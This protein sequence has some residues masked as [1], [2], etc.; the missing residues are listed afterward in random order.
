MATVAL[1]TAYCI[2]MIFDSSRSLYLPPYIRAPYVDPGRESTPRPPFKLQDMSGIGSDALK[3]RYPVCE[4]ENDVLKLI[5]Y[6]V[7]GVGR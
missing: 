2:F 3:L 6:K 7:R 4:L 1:L 5:P